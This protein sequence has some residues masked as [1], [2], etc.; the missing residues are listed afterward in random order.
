MCVGQRPPQKSVFIC[1]HFIPLN[2]KINSTEYIDFIIHIGMLFLV[3]NKTD[4]LYYK[5]VEEVY[6]DDTIGHKTR[7]E[8]SILY[9]LGFQ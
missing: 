1:C 4:F 8:K 9:E 6:I 5:R 7:Y 2:H 3:A